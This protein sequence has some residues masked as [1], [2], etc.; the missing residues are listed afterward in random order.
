MEGQRELPFFFYSNRQGSIKLA[1]QCVGVCTIAEHVTIDWVIII[2]G[3]FL[4]ITIRNVYRVGVKSWYR[5]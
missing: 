2:H 5:C 1:L 4:S 3:N